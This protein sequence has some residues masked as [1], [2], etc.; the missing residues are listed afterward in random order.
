[1]KVRPKCLGCGGSGGL[2]FQCA[3]I[4]THAKRIIEFL[5]AVLYAGA[6]D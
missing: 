5:A 1:M 3:A 2:Y 6:R 4:T